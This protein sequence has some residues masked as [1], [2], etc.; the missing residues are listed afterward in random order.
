MDARAAGD[1]VEECSGGQKYDAKHE[2]SVQ[3]EQDRG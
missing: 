3:D 1:L 2:V